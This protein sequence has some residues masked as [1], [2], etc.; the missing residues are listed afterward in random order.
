M[1]LTD[2][3]NAA[4]MICLLPYFAIRLIFWKRGH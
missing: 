1:K 2:A 3:L 4:K